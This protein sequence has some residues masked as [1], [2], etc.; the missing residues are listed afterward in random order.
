[1]LR[2]LD[3]SR[4]FGGP[5]RLRQYQF[6]RSDHQICPTILHIPYIV[7]KVLQE[8]DERGNDRIDVRESAEGFTVREQSKVRR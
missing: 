1:M 3:T 6:G 8:D 5:E 7:G 2:F 4:N